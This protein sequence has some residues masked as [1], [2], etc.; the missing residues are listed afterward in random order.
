[1]SEEQRVEVLS[2]RSTARGSSIGL[3]ARIFAL[4]DFY[5]PEFDVSSWKE[6]PVPSNWE[7]QGYGT[8]IYTN[9]TYPV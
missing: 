7:M 8:P 2:S 9:I 6:I 5:K 1:M 4:S 3:R